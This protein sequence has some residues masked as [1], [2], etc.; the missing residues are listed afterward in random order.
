MTF[1]L[2]NIGRRGEEYAAFYPSR[3]P[4]VGAGWFVVGVNYSHK[5][6]SHRVCAW[7]DVPQP[8]NRFGNVVK[9]G[10]ETKSGARDVAYWLRQA[11]PWRFPGLMGLL[12]RERSVRYAA[13]IDQPKQHHH[14]SLHRELRGP[15]HGL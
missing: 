5:S 6:C 15:I 9:I 12:G 4:E 10:W 7:P 13:Q 3:M 14:T 1:V 8:K 2:N 11:K